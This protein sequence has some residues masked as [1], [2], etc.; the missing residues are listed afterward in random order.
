M[1]KRLMLVLTI[2]IALTVTVRS[3]Q[4]HPDFSGKWILKREM[5]DFGTGPNGQR[6]SPRV[7]TMIIEQDETNLKVIFEFT[8]R[9]GKKRKNTYR[10]SLKGKKTENKMNF[11]K[12][13]SVTRWIEDGQML[14]IESV[15]HIKRGDMEFDMESVQYFTI[16]EGRLVIESVRY[17]PRGD[18]ETRAVYERDTDGDE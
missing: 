12:Q 16:V 2:T 15:S 6:R 13:K 10:Y 3:Q 8:D 14:E 1:L 17:T 4:K 7:N 9:E 5:S 11:G 18:M